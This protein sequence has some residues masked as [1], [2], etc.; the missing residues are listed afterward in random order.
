MYSIIRN[1]NKEWWSGLHWT[2]TRAL[3]KRFR[4]EAAAQHYLETYKSAALYYLSIK[5]VN[6]VSMA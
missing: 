3:A 4:S 1:D 2:S 5:Q 6:I